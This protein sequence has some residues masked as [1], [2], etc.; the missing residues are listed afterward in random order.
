[1]MLLKFYICIYSQVQDIFI[2]SYI[3]H[4]IYLLKERSKFLS[5]SGPPLWHS[6]VLHIASVNAVC[7]CSVEI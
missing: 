7:E 3:L 2:C 1:M 5:R 6:L 4:S